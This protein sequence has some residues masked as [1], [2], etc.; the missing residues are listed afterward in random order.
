MNED[1]FFAVTDEDPLG[2]GKAGLYA[3]NNGADGGYS[4]SY[5]WA[6][7]IRVAYVDEDND[8]VPDDTDNCEEVHNPGQADWNDNGVGDACGDP[9][10][11]D[12]GEP[13]TGGPGT[14]DDT[15]LPGGIKGNIELENLGCGCTTSG[16]STRG[17]LAMPLLCLGLLFGRRRR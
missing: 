6:S 1:T 10:P 9:P 7:N 13:D 15:G 12:T 5:C 4:S 14:G 2:P 17:L 3:Y 11:S 8:G 16:G